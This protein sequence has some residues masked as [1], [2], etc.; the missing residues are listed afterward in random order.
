[1]TT[2]TA[3][4]PKAARTKEHRRSP[5]KRSILEAWIS[6]PTATDPSKRMEVISVDLSKHGV[7]FDASVPVPNQTYYIIEIGYGS[8]KITAEIRTVSCRKLCDGLYH[9]GAE[10]H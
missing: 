3:P 6:S 8:Q 1:M 10:F 4:A 7:A 5:R 2:Q 9:V